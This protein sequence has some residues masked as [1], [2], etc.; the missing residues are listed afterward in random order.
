MVGPFAFL[1]AA[2]AVGNATASLAAHEPFD[3]GIPRSVLGSFRR[4]SESICMAID[5]STATTG[6]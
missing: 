1:A 2:V 4:G 5:S 6:G 3:T